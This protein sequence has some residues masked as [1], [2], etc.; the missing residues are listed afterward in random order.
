MP[1]KLSYFLVFLFL[2]LIDSLQAQN[3]TS[4]SSSGGISAGM[5]G[6][7]VTLSNEWAAF[8]NI[9][10]LAANPDLQTS[11]MFAIENRFGL[12]DFNSYHLGLV[13]P[14]SFGGV[15][16]LTVNRFGDKYYNETKVGL[17]YSHQVSL[18]SIGAKV[19]YL[20][21][22]VN[23]QIGITQGSRSTFLLEI[24]AMAN[25]SKKWAFGIYGYNFTQSQLRTRQGGK[26]RIPVVLRAGVSYKPYEKLFL[27]VETEKDLDYPLLVRA[28]VNYK[29]HPYFVVRTGISTN[30]FNS[31]FGISFCPKNISF[32]YAL[33]NNSAL[34]WLHNLSLRYSF[35]KKQAS[36]S[37]DSQIPQP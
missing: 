22:A 26:D 14:L 13:S 8:N 24:G 7:G 6:V 32:D 2:I 37:S 28:G 4:S 5:A 33:S 10:A 12:K 19:D 3:I 1:K 11:A 15:G 34:G 23:D 31:A 20:Q 17:G 29:I 16:G 36:A 21:V 25:L 30:P 9:G 27:S 18:V 35:Q